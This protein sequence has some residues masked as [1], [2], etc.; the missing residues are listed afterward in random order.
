MI[1]KT[2]LVG[3]VGNDPIYKTLDATAGNGVVTFSLATSESWTKNGEKQT[4]TEWHNCKAFG[5]LALII[6]EWVK[7]GQLLYV[8]GKIKTR[9]WDQD[10]AKKY[11]TEIVVDQMQ[12]LGKK[13]S[14][15]KSGLDSFN[16]FDNAT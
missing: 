16:E 5:K 7:K 10:G 4:S 1:N 11:M 12:M 14:D 3:N 6:D 9:S 15:D 13:Q 2:I 8:E